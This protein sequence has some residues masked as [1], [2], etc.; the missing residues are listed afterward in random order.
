M[1]EAHIKLQCFAVTV[2]TPTHMSGECGPEE[3]RNQLSHL[4][5]SLCAPHSAPEHCQAQ[6]S[7]TVCCSGFHKCLTFPLSILAYSSPASAVLRGHGLCWVL[8]D[9]QC[10]EPQ[11]NPSVLLFLSQSNYLAF[12]MAGLNSWLELT[13]KVIE[14][15]NKIRTS[16]QSVFLT[17]YQME[18]AT[19]EVWQATWLSLSD[20]QLITFM[21][22]KTF[23]DKK[24]KHILLTLKYID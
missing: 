22:A 17:S 5:Q 21:F 14:S 19:W 6:S 16:F 2:Q 18:S 7:E 24:Q 1:Q 10:S 13:E 4:N 3:K 9:N 12:L 23:R 8:S 11:A 15:K 20:G